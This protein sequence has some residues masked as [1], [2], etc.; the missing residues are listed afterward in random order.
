[1]QRRKQK[2]RLRR[3]QPCPAWVR[4]TAATSRESVHTQNEP[5]G[6]FIKSVYPDASAVPKA[7]GSISG[8]P[9]A[10]IPSRSQ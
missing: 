3:S 5:Q 4:T 8:Y 7:P 2:M 1:M 10:F 6:E 9:E